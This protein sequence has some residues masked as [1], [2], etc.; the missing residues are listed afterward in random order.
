MLCRFCRISSLLFLITSNS[1]GLFGPVDTVHKLCR[2]K[3]TQVL[4]HIRCGVNVVVATFSMV[5]ETVSMLHTQIQTL[6]THNEKY[7]N[8][9][10]W[11]KFGTV[12]V[13]KLID[14]IYIYTVYIYI[15]F[16]VYN[17]FFIEALLVIK[18]MCF[19]KMTCSLT[20]SLETSTDWQTSG[21]LTS[22]CFSQLLTSSL[23]FSG[24]AENS[25][26]WWS[27]NTELSSKMP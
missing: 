6:D 1:V 15:T 19:I 22:K 26:G 18:L 20:G 24:Q 12:H 13:I 8:T 10:L 16:N 4:H 9:L 21:A 27:K 14:F 25:L 5:T 7:K 2:H 23:V 11:R 17:S 3:V